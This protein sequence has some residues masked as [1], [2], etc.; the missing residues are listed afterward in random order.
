MMEGAE[1]LFDKNFFPTDCFR[2]I[3]FKEAYISLLKKGPKFFSLTKEIPEILISR[4]GLP[5]IF[6]PGEWP[7]K[8]F[9]PGEGPQD[10]RFSISSAPPQIINGRP[11]TSQ[12]Y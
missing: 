12:V 8:I 1:E 9:S 11:L 3:F 4:V 10:S 2:E 6:F 7:P 5:E